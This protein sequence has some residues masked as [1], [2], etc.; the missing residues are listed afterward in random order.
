MRQ[1]KAPR[2]SV[3]MPNHNCLAYLK[4]AVASVQ[5]QTMTD[6]E[7][8]VADDDSNDGSREWLAVAAQH[9]S[10]IR[11]M[12]VNVHHP[13]PSRNAAIQ[14]AQGQWLAFLDADDHWQPA[15]LQRQ[16][17]F[18]EAN[19]T[20]V[21]SFTDYRHVN[22][23]SRDL[24]S[25]FEFW[26]LNRLQA[27]NGFQSLDNA[28]E[29]FFGCNCVGT[30]TVMVRTDAIWQVGGFDVSLP[31]AEDWDLWLKLAAAGPIGYSSD[32]AT[33]YLMRVGSESSKLSLRVEALER[34]LARHANNLS[35]HASAKRSALARIANAKSDVAQASN[36]MGA[37]LQ[38]KVHAFMLQPSTRQARELIALLKPSF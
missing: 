18:H 14:V 28:F 23:Q 5:A 30:S 19:P 8:I 2:C 3:I 20:T 6:W 10:R 34:I 22:E 13:A 17:A 25:C 15:K 11:P 1:S 26:Q 37:A 38:A 4:Q 27:S 32:C 7:L 16:L 35:N 21:L 33:T 29:V 31:S 36:R 24:G 12:H 9:D